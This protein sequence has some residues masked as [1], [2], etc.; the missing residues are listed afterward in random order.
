MPCILRGDTIK[1]GYITPAFSAARKWAELLR[2][3]CIVGGPQK[4][5]EIKSGYITRAFSGA[6]KWAKL[7]HNRWRV[8]GWNLPRGGG[9]GLFH[10]AARI[11]RPQARCINGP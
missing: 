3:P 5:D 9:G 2:N 1:N 8:G 7:L 6:H 10:T 11:P 4:R